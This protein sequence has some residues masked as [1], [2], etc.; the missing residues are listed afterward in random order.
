MI[1]AAAGITLFVGS[2]TGI[3]PASAHVRAVSDN[4]VRGGHAL[5]TFSVPN[6]SATGALTTALTVTLPDVAS[7]STET[8]PGWTARLDR[9]VA[10]GTVKSVTWTAAPN[11][12]IAVDQFALFRISVTLPDAETVSFPAAQ[13]YSDGSTVTWDQPPLPDGTEPEHP[14]P[15]LTLAE[16]TAS[17][18]QHTT[19]SD[20]RA[21]VVA[22]DGPQSRPDNTARMLAGA[23]LLVG[24]VGIAVALVRRRA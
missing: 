16:P 13:T 18:Q 12:G 5:V 2:A 10:A 14:A 22:G 23:A 11:A 1:T 8:M 24:A 17:P 15:M 7:A 4:S 21:V 9:D 19:A 20:Q 3:A 6:E